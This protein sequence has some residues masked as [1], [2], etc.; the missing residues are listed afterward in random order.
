[1]RLDF[2]GVK[3]TLSKNFLLVMAVVIHFGGDLDSVVQYVQ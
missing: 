3:K 1:M 2:G